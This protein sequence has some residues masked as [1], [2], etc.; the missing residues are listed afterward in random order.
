MVVFLLSFL[1]LSIFHSSFLPPFIPSFFPSLLSP[2][3]TGNKFLMSYEWWFKMYH[4]ILLGT[5]F[6]CFLNCTGNLEKWCILIVTS[7]IWNI[8]DVSTRLGVKKFN[9]LLIHWDFY[10]CMY[11]FQSY[12]LIWNFE[13]DLVINI[14]RDKELQFNNGSNGSD[15]SFESYL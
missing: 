3:W 5:H 8:V 6:I 14:S 1:L 13:S 15:I 4:C 11:L 12:M 2:L 10:H 9:L 7:I